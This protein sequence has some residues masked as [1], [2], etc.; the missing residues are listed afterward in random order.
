MKLQQVKQELLEATDKYIQETNK[1]HQKNKTSTYHNNLNKQEIKGIRSLQK[2]KELIIFTTDKTGTFTADTPDNY[3]EASE[4]HTLE[5]E[6]ITEEKHQKAQKK[7]NAHATIWARFTNAGTNTGSE[8][9]PDRIKANLMVENNGHAPLYALRKDHKPCEDEKKGPKTRPVCSG[10]SAYNRKLSHLISMIIRP[11][12]Q[13]ENTVSTNTEEVMSAFSDVNKENVETELLVGSADV[14]ALYPSLD[15]TH[16][17]EI[18]AQTFYE[19]DY[20][21]NEIDTKDLGLYIALNLTPEE[22]KEENLSNHCPTRKHTRGTPPVIT[23]CAISNDIS[24]RHGPWNEPENTTPDENTTKKMMATALKIVIKFI[25][26]NHIYNINGKLKRQT[27]GGPIGLELTGDIAQV[28]MSW[29][30]KQL[31]RKLAESNII[32]K[33]YKRYVD[34]INFII[35]TQRQITENKTKQEREE[36]DKE[37]MEKIRKI[38]NTIHKSIEIETDTPALH[39]DKKMP[40]L[41]LKVW[42]EIRED[43]EGKKTSKIIHEFYYKEIAN[44]Q[45]THADSAMSMSSKR[46]ILTSEMLR[47]LLRCSPLLPWQTTAQHASEMNKRMQLSGYGY[48]FRRQVTNAALNKYK[49]IKENDKKGETPMYRNK[50]WKRAERDRKKQQNKTQWY[51]KGKTKYKSI[52]FV[53][54][55]PKSKLQ[56]EYSK[57]IKKH[58]MKIKVVEKAGIQV[59]NLIQK[60]E[61]FKQNKCNDKDCFPCTSSKNNKHTNC[62]KDGV[63]YYITCNTC[64]AQYVGESS[65]NGNTRG[66]EHLND[67]ETNRDS[68]IMLRHIQT[69]HR[70][71]EQRPTFT[72]TITQIY[73]N[74]C[75]DRQ[76]SEAIQINNIPDEDRINNKTEY[77]QHIFPRTSLTWI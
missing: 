39:E 20:E 32:L 13:E 26:G 12:W 14:K 69:H 40:I 37:T 29:W 3:R 21:I 34:D 72:M 6:D 76:L 10:S 67:Y 55:T 33:L 52:I 11:L 45:V 63:I 62:R 46:S 30:D 53:P 43:E 60:S 73:N 24:K 75:M 51:K 59:K 42:A 4:I 25:M 2:N 70:H 27:K 48:Q 35:N 50:D 19:S 36:E 5:D 1:N 15:I 41:D 68:S 77:I 71:D 58:K 57:I 54:A 47:V 7:A 44:K 22:I 8:T 31:I 64:R 74:R 56:K 38:G 61:P 65:R 18:V 49:Q 9:A 17:A 66:K 16:T 23:G 28:Y